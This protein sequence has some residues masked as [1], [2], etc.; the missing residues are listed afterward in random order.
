MLFS[1]A[2]SVI[3]CR[4]ESIVST[5]SLPATASSDVYS[6][7]I[8]PSTAISICFVPFFPFRYSSK[9]YSIPVFPIISFCEYVSFLVSYSSALIVDAYPNIC[10]ARVPDVYSLTGSTTI[11]I[12]GNLSPLSVNSATASLGIS[13]A[14]VNAL[15]LLY[16]VI[17]ISYLIAKIFLTSLISVFCI[18]YLSLKW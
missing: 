6:D 7:V 15:V 14:I 11:F 4:F 12:P 13:S 8:V 2:C 16:P 17:V 9:T 5:T 10:E 3:F 18:S 1:N